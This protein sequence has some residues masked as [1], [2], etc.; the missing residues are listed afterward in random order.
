MEIDGRTTLDLS[1]T[2]GAFRIVSGQAVVFA[3]IDGDGR[4]HPLVTLDVG[5]VTFGT[6]GAGTQ[7]V[8]VFAMGLERCVL[9]PLL[10][11][12]APQGGGAGAGMG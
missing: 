3:V 8:R 6:A 10:P 1:D 12:A 11:G 5:D 4:R 2:E 9:V 7:G